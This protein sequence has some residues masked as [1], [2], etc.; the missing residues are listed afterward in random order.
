[1]LRSNFT[2]NEFTYNWTCPIQSA[3]RKCLAKQCTATADHL[4]C[5]HVLHVQVP[6]VDAECSQQLGSMQCTATREAHGTAGD[7]CIRSTCRHHV[8]MRPGVR[9]CAAAVV[10]PG[11]AGPRS[12]VAA[13]LNS[14]A[15]LQRGVLRGAACA[16]ALRKLS[17]PFTASACAL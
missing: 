9:I 7:R 2:Y 1:M 11:H 10:A 17:G 15:A 13:F 12:S 4:D 14:A 6:V 5:L 3:A 16:A 8:V